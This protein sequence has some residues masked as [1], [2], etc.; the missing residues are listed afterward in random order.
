MLEIR[1]PLDKEWYKVTYIND[2][3]VCFEEQN[4]EYKGEIPLLHAKLR[5]KNEDGSYYLFDK[6]IKED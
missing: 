3:W 4:Q 6:L 1:S 2:N 5:F